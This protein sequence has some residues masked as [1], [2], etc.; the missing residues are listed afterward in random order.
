MVDAVA[1][2]VPAI[3]A[4][5]AGTLVDTLANLDGRVE[6]AAGAAGSAEYKADQAQAKADQ[7]EGQA[8]YAADTAGAAQGTAQ[9]AA[10]KAGFLEYHLREI[11]ALVNYNMPAA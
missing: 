5:P 11:A 2:N 4:I 7:V 6:Y 8:Q 3:G 9:Y 1:V 10:D